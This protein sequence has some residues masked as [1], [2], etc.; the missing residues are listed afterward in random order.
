MRHFSRRFG[1]SFI[2]LVIAGVF[3]SSAGSA[4][5]ALSFSQSNINLS[6]GQ[7]TTINVTGGSD[8]YL[9]SNSNPNAALGRFNGS[10]LTIT[11]GSETGTANVTVC[12]L[13]G[14]NNCGSVTVVVGGSNNS[15]TTNTTTSGPTLSPSSISPSLGS[16]QSI[17]ISGN[18]N[19]FVSSNSNSAVASYTLTGSILQVTAL[20]NG[21]ATITVCQ[22]GGCSNLTITVGSGGN[23][24]G[25]LSFSQSNPSLSVGQTIIVTI[26]GGSGVYSL[27]SISNT[28]VASSSLSGN[29][30]TIIG[31]AFGSATLS[32]CE[33]GGSCNSLPVTVTG[34]TTNTSSNASQ[35]TPT[36]P[37]ISQVP[38]VVFPSTLINQITLL[39]GQLAQMTSQLAQLKATIQALISGSSIVPLS[40]SGSSGSTSVNTT[41]GSS[42]KFY[43]PLEHGDENQEVTELQ[44]RLTAEGFYSG[45]VTGYFGPLT[46]QAVQAYQRAHGLTPL[47]NVGP[48]TR[49]ALN[50]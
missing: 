46:E 3:L 34:T 33:S 35:T 41:A 16:T 48:G 14:T 37:S 10:T 31:K 44:K 7:S 6:S 23:T 30:L 19:Y 36:Q 11:A 18:G 29:T 47:G 42:Y 8:Y 2:S 39:E 45:P 49:E 38:S 1:A 5:A 40:T 21:S 15:N 26:S 22:T 9:S 17:T 20:S 50:Q 25:V 13:S 43:Y 12:S 32:L 27:S 28:N 24:G 4:F